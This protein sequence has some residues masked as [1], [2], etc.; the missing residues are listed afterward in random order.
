[1]T[2]SD[3][4]DRLRE[5]IQLCSIHHQRMSFAYGKIEKYFPLT[6]EKYISL[7][8]VELSF[9]DQLIFRFSRLQDG[10]GGKFFP[11]LL[12]SLGEEVRGV[13]FIDLLTKL[14]ELNLLD[15]SRKWLILR[16]TRNILNHEYPF[17]TE[18]VIEGLNQ[19]NDHYQLIVSIWK[20]LEQYSTQRFKF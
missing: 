14:E 13:P 5:A 6:R 7:D 18:E 17:I 3:K 9:F 15:D 2:Q 16:E 12:E 8:P 10:I 20:R 11:A 4:E 1:M 19:L